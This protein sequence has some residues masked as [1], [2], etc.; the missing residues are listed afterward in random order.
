MMPMSIAARILAG[1]SRARNGERAPRL[2]SVNS[3]TSGSTGTTALTGLIRGIDR[4]HCRLGLGFRVQSTGN[5]LMLA[6]ELRQGPERKQ[7]RTAGQEDLRGRAGD[8]LGIG[9]AD[10][11]GE[12]SHFHA[13]GIE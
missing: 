11:L 2:E 10:Q 13:A 1:P 12:F 9:E 5:W 6:A 3:T 4:A 7:G 8:D